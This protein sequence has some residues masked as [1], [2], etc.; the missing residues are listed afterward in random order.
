MSVR[1]PGPIWINVATKITFDS[2]SKSPKEFITL[3][4]AQLKS[5]DVF[6]VVHGNEDVT[7]EP[8]GNEKGERP[9]SNMLSDLIGEIIKSKKNG[10]FFKMPRVLTPMNTKVRIH[11]S[12]S[13]SYAQ[14]NTQ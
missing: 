1:V 10:I 13:E 3:D 11:S 5:P 14:S 2:G 12:T 6:C 7:I 4:N 9:W 8:G